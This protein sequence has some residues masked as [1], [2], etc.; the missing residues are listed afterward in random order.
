MYVRTFPLRR[1]GI[2]ALSLSVAASIAAPAFAAM[3]NTASSYGLF[4]GD[5]ASAQALS[6]FNPQ[7]SSLYYNPSY[8]IKDPRGE[9]TIGFLHAEQELDGKSLGAPLRPHA[10]ATCSMTAAASSN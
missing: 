7:A 5:V 2:A 9:L 10:T 3:G 1:G 4:P 8:L 6:M